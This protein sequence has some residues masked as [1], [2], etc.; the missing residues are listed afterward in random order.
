M[1][2]QKNTA[3]CIKSF[4]DRFDVSYKYSEKY[5][6]SSLLFRV[7]L[8]VSVA[9]TKNHAEQIKIRVLCNRCIYCG[10]KLGRI[11]IVT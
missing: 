10:R 6:E 4:R 1:L 9:E 2:R 5:A 11:N 3:T 8:F 7:F